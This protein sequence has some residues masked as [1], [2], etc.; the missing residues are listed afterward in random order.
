VEFV[1]FSAKEL[2]SSFTLI[3]PLTA[4]ILS[5]YILHQMSGP[6]LHELDGILLFHTLALLIFPQALPYWPSVL[7]RGASTSVAKAFMACTYMLMNF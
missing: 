7:G 4:N 1:H 3:V 6:F 5:R 2:D